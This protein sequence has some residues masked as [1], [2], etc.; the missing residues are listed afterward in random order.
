MANI[1][2]M[3]QHQPVILNIT[4]GDSAVAIMHRANIPGDY[5]PWRDVLHEGPV[6]NGLSLEALSTIRAE[7][8]AEQQ[9]GDADQVASGF[10]Q[11]DQLLQRWR[12]Y[13]KVMLWFEHDLYDQLQLLQILDWFAEQ[14]FVPGR[15]TLI[16][17]EQY[18]GAITADELT[19]LVCFELPIN[20]QQLSLAQSAWS[21][22]RSATPEPWAALLR[23]DISQLPFL[24]DAIIRLLEEYP[25]PYNG[26]SRTQSQALSLIAE[27]Q[28]TP[29]RLFELYQRTE[30]RRFLGDLTFWAILRQM[31]VSTPPLLEVT[32][33]TDLTIPPAAP[34]QELNITASGLQALRGELSWLQCHRLDRWLGGVHLTTENVWFWDAEQK[35]LCRTDH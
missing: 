3:H 35:R 24:H 31:T 5:L 34:G 25:H 28:I 4:N 2:F 33:G 10:R 16:C 18:L 22:F 23:Q 26:L 11:R 13:S 7:F 14:P 12:E 21:A 15:L 20:E 32:N 19:S 29:V 27:Q 9:W 1:S 30:Q 8:I 6:P 17:T